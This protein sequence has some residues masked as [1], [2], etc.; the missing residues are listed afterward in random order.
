MSQMLAVRR[1]LP[2]AHCSA[3]ITDHHKQ[4]DANSGSCHT[5]SPDG[6]FCDQ[7]ATLRPFGRSK[8]DLIRA[9]NCSR[10]SASA[11]VLS[12][13]RFILPD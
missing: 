6:K 7:P 13:V 12:D 4:P 11:A 8:A 1:R 10:P 5:T 2:V 9:W 3:S